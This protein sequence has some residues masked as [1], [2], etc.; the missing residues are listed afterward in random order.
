MPT[1]KV[2]FPN[3]IN[4]RVLAD[5]TRVE[6]ARHAL[7]LTGAAIKINRDRLGGQKNLSGY[8]EKALRHAGFIID[9]AEHMRGTGGKTAQTSIRTESIDDILGRMHQWEKD[10]GRKASHIGTYVECMYLGGIMDLMVNSSVAEP[11][12][13]KD[14]AERVKEFQPAYFRAWGA[15]DIACLFNDALW[16]LQEQERIAMGAAEII[17]DAICNYGF[18]KA[19]Y[20]QC[21]KIIDAPNP[22]G[23][24]LACDEKTGKMQLKKRGCS[25]QMTPLSLQVGGV[26]V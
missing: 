7:F 5:Y 14:R 10:H 2:R 24:E 9:V 15:G 12:S 13:I 21:D 16:P 22:N 4:D 17:K 3:I 20:Y 26:P 1:R 18:E 23:L 19:R 8:N 25:T 6:K 11:I